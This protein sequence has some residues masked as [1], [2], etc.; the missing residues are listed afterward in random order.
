L[1]SDAFHC[2]DA[3]GSRPD[4][5]HDPEGISQ[6]RHLAPHPA[7]LAP[8]DTE[9]KEG[10]REE[11]STTNAGAGNL[12]AMHNFLSARAWLRLAAIFKEAGWEVTLGRGGGHGAF[13]GLHMTGPGYFP[14]ATEKALR[15][16]GRNTHLLST[17][18]KSRPQSAEGRREERKVKIAI[19]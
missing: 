14:Q 9:R 16:A 15:A 18:P 2:C 12:A 1:A 6:R 5:R 10:S 17:S 11:D 3:S 19:T 8:D 13:E 7:H 4:D